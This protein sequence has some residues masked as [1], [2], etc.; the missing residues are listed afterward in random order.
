M[1]STFTHG[2]YRCCWV[3]LGRSYFSALHPPLS[4]T[5]TPQHHL[6]MYIRML[7]A[8]TLMRT[9]ADILSSAPAMQIRYLETMQAMAKSANSKVNYLYTTVSSH[10]INT[11][12]RSSS[13]QLRI[14]LSNLLSPRQTPPAK[15]PA[16]T[17]LALT[18]AVPRRACRAAPHR[19]MEATTMAS[20]AL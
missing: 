14:R 13:F 5:T 1:V 10:T 17:C 11:Y 19:S 4:F 2:L 18:K 20:R 7:T 16:P 9:A 12:L 15:A 6:H 3:G 8:L